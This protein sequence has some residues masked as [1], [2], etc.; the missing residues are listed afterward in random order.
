MNERGLMTGFVISKLGIA[1]ACII[2]FLS[3]TSIYHKSDRAIQR[4]K[5]HHIVRIVAMT[6]READS[7]PGIV[8]INR[9]LPSPESTYTLSIE[10][11]V[12]DSQVV[13]IGA[14]PMNGIQQTIFVS[15]KVNG[16]KFSIEKKNPSEVLIS[17]DNRILLEIV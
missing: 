2:L 9:E 16:G 13:R 10:G 6:L 1:F 14:G 15:R 4:R 12:S 3:A 8:D 5:Y 7:T 11:N 17:K